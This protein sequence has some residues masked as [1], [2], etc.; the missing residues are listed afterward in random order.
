[1]NGNRYPPGSSSPKGRSALSPRAAFVLQPPS[2]QITKMV[3]G[4]KKLSE[5]SPTAEGSACDQRAAGE[6]RVLTY[7]LFVP[8]VP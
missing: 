7:G 1:M 8:D 6:T 5:S 3:T 2:C 4:Q